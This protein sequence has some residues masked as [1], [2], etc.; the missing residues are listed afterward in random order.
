MNNELK[1]LFN[2]RNNIALRVVRLKFYEQSVYIFVILIKF[3]FDTWYVKKKIK[4]KNRFIKSV[5]II[6]YGNKI[7]QK[8]I[9]RKF[10]GVTLC[11]TSEEEINLPRLVNHLKIYT[12]SLILLSSI[13]IKSTLDNPSLKSYQRKK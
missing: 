8:L 13:K 6:S 1:T 3:F 2:I 5:S 4:Q 11:V 10:F 12:L 7:K 9:C